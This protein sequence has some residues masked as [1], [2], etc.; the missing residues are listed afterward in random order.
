MIAIKETVLKELTFGARVAEEEAGE[1]ASYFVET[2]QWKQVW[3]D[4]VDIVYG[5]KGSGKS[6]IYATLA[7]RESQLFDRNI[8]ISPAES[9]QGSPAFATLE[10]NAVIDEDQFVGLWKVYFLAVIADTFADYDLRG[11]A[12]KL[13]VRTLT[14]AGMVPG[15]NVSLRQ[16]LANAAAYVRRMFSEIE[17]SVSVAG[18]V[19]LGTRIRFTEPDDVQRSKGAMHVDELLA[20]AGQALE[21]EGLQLWLLLDRL[22][23]AFAGKPHLEQQALRALF[24]V[25]LDLGNIDRIRLK[26]FLRSDIWKAITASGFREASH[27]TRELTLRW[28]RAALLQLVTQRLVRNKTLRDFYG[29]TQDG[30]ASVAGQEDLFQRVYPE[31]VENGPNKPKTFDWCLSRTSDGTKRTAPRELIHLLTE[32]RGVQLRRQ[33]VGEDEPVGD[34]LFDGSS[35]K[36][37]LP[38]VSETRLTK[39]LYAEHPDLKRFMSALEGHKTNH[40]VQSLAAI[41][42]C[43]Q[44][45][46]KA[47]ALRL[48]DIGFFEK[49]AQMQFWVPFLYRPALDLVQGSAEGVS[50]PGDVPPDDEDSSGA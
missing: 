13:V 41:W 2:E 24:K 39:T 16:K 36:G 9:P 25:Y 32:A 14:D 34:V 43:P 6:A 17:P 7:A 18:V 38:A 11:P 45:E 21:D 42:E 27:I 10:A 31:Q 30:V 33:E 19:D 5:P 15:R 3:Q 35:L 48:V 46:A 29:A 4:K 28:D 23:V 1:L 22:D 26:I 49:R 20:T 37:A 44:D 50:I 8:L 12:A 47:A 40:S